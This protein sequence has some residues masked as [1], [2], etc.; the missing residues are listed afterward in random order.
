MLQHLFLTN[1]SSEKLLYDSWKCLFFTAAYVGKVVFNVQCSHVVDYHCS[2]P[3]CTLTASDTVSCMW[4]L[5]VGTFPPSSLQ[6][7]DF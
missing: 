2:L 1:Q 6:L 5:P 7:P 3:L 4:N